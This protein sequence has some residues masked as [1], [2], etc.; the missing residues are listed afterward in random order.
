MAWTATIRSQPY[1]TNDNTFVVDMGFSDGVSVIRKQV[2]IGVPFD[3]DSFKRTVQAFLDNLNASDTAPIK[4]P[5]GVFDT[6][7]TPPVLSPAEQARLAY[8]LD[9]TLFGQMNRAI[10]AGAKKNTDQ[11]YVDL[12]ARLLTN[13]IDS[14]IDLF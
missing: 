11:N 6:T 5:I 4:L 13:F 7:I 1:K 8:S 3:L 14:Y 9:V 12:K 10:E 2:Q